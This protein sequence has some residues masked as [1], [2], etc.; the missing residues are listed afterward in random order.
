MRDVKEGIET[1]ERGLGARR[2][3]VLL[4]QAGLTPRQISEVRGVNL[5][6]TLGYIDQAIGAGLLR[7]SDVLF[8][9]PEGV[10]TAPRGPGGAAKPPEGIVPGQHPAD[11][12]VVERYGSAAHALGDMY[13]HLCAI[14][15]RLHEMVRATLVQNLGEHE[16]GWWRQGIPESIRKV[17]QARR[18]EDEHPAPHAYHYTDLL[19]LGTVIEANWGVL[20]SVLPEQYR[21]ARKAILKDLR[22]L[23]G[24]RRRVM[25]PVRHAPPDEDD[26]RFTRSLRMALIPAEATV[27][28]ADAALV[29]GLKRA[30]AAD[31]RRQ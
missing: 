26:F 4:V 14:E 29:A 24:I 25:H 13:E 6:T 27:P 19:D 16:G 5:G 20:A 11:A 9:L 2:T 23:N 15:Q 30:F 31:R 10:R 3:T 28:E 18:E 22:R 21:G 17:C 8:T 12:A 1:L 7:R